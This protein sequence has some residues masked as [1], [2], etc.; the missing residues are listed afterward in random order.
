MLVTSENLSHQSHLGLAWSIWP[1]SLDL[2][3]QGFIGKNSLE[4]IATDGYDKHAK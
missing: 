4:L 3:H 1:L 2:L